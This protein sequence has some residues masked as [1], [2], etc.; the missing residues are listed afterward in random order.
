MITTEKLNLT[1]LGV[2]EGVWVCVCADAWLHSL[3]LIS[4]PPGAVIP[5]AR[6]G[7]ARQPPQPPGVAEVGITGHGSL[8]PNR[9]G[10]SATVNMWTTSK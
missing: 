6:Q 4:V 5:H 2:V 9:S 1:Y 8:W 10:H 7:K 3:A